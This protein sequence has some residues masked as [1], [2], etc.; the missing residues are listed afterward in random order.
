[1]PAGSPL[2]LLSK[3]NERCN[4]VDIINIPPHLDPGGWKPWASPIPTV[5]TDC[6]RSPDELMALR[7]PPSVTHPEMYKVAPK[8]LRGT[9]SSLCAQTEAE[10]LLG[11]DLIN[12]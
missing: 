5:P 11:Y 12:F 2:R 9:V 1:M 3:F 8:Q 4:I 10:N 6:V 7:R